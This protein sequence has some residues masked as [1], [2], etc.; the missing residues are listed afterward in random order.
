MWPW[1]SLGVS[2]REV[3]A[4]AEGSTPPAMDFFSKTLIGVRRA[5]SGNGEVRDERSTVCVVSCDA[6]PLAD[7]RSVPFAT[8]HD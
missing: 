3:T 4:L 1:V 6:I 8:G 2:V 5:T 7:S